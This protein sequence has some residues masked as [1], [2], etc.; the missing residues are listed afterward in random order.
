MENLGGTG[1]LVTL[2]L[3]DSAIGTN[4]EAVGL[5]LD[6]L[7]TAI[8]ETTLN[9]QLLSHGCT[10]AVRGGARPR[11]SWP[12]GSYKIQSHVFEVCCG[13]VCSC[14]HTYNCAMS[15][16]PV[17]LEGKMESTNN[18]VFVRGGRVRKYSNAGYSSLGGALSYSASRSR[19]HARQS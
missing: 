13:R 7:N 19:F 15:S 16:L 5:T 10:E 14:L 9:V 6:E 17:D 8:A 18:G 4:A 2:G 1:E 12:R 3:V 11:G